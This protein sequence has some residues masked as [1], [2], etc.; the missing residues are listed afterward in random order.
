[1]SLLLNIRVLIALAIVAAL[2]FSHF[3][4]Y[5]AGKNDVRKEWLAAT[6]AANIEANR[7]ERA[8]Q[9]GVDEAQAAA[10]KR[11]GVLAA[12][13]RASRVLVGGLRNDIDAAERVAAQSAAAADQLRAAYRELYVESTE[14]LTEIAGAADQHS[15]DVRLLREAWP[16]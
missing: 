8:R 2:G 3:T 9:R 7:M 4:V 14:L 5:R 1:V 11:S 12:D 10:A 6:A 16:K 15:S 13:A